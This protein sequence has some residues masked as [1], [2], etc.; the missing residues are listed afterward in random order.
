MGDADV[1]KMDWL[2]IVRGEYL[3]MPG[4]QLTQSQAR[5]LWGLNDLECAKVLAALVKESFLRQTKDG[6]YTLA[7]SSAH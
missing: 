6:R 4:L 2:K 7:G 5:R 3:E 1:R